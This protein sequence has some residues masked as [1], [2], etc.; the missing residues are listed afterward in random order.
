VLGVD[1]MRGELLLIEET[2]GD[3]SPLMG[4]STSVQRGKIR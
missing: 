4:Y 1:V 3:Y 2:V